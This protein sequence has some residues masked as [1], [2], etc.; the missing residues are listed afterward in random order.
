MGSDSWRFG[1]YAD[2]RKSPGNAGVL[3]QPDGST[4]FLPSDRV[5]VQSA[6]V[7]INRALY[8]YVWEND[9]RWIEG[10]GFVSPQ[11]H[12]EAQR[13]A[14]LNRRDNALI[15]EELRREFGDDFD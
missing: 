11:F 4:G 15:L 14:E 12:A 6:S 9:L 7:V 2:H 3:G 13:I 10:L 1:L 5:G 8:D